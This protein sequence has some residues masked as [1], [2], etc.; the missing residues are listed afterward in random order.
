MQA[1]MCA[2]RY[3]D[4]MSVVKSNSALLAAPFK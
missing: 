1:I 2:N 3:I 4:I